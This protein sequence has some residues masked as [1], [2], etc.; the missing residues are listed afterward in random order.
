[1][2]V[3]LLIYALYT[4]LSA[5]V[6]SIRIKK[7]WGFTENI[8][9][10]VTVLIAIFG[11]IV[12]VLLSKMTAF[13]IATFFIG[14]V[15]VRGILY[16]AFLNCFRNVKIDYQSPTTNSKIDKFEN[17]LKWD[18]WKQRRVYLYSLLTILF[19]YYLIRLLL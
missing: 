12:I 6:E 4:I 1:M 3:K 7:S 13:Q 5:Y 16:D 17:F 11:P 10:F 15:F 2:I 9:K 8:N 19:I 18:F 14:C